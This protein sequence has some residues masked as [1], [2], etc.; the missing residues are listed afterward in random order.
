LRQ[1]GSMP[2]TGNRMA[3]MACSMRSTNIVTD[4][5]GEEG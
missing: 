4:D 1:N 3:A 5:G 2:A